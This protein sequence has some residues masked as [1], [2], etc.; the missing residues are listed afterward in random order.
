MTTTRT[1]PIA[2][3]HAAAERTAIRLWG[4]LHTLNARSI[5]LPFGANP[6]PVLRL[7][8]DLENELFELKKAVS[9]VGGD[10]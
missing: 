8:A 6:Y 5:H 2:I 4:A 9:A 1:T 3:K 7:I 10:R